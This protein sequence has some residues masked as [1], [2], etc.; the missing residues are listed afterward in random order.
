MDLHTVHLAASAVGYQEVI[1]KPRCVGTHKY[2]TVPEAPGI[3]LAGKDIRQGHTLIIPGT[4][5]VV[6]D[7]PSELIHGNLPRLRSL[8]LAVG[9]VKHLR[10]DGKVL[11]LILLCRQ[12][13]AYHAV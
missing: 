7:A 1:L 8:Q 3:D 9:V 5:G 2:D 4:T 13:P 6:D 12:A 11:P 10:K